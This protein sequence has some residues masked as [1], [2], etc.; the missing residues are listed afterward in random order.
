MLAEANDVCSLIGLK[1]N[2]FV[3]GL[4]EPTMK[5]GDQLI[6]KSQNM[7]KVGV[8]SRLRSPDSCY[9]RFLQTL[10]SVSAVAKSVYERAFKWIVTKC[11]SSLRAKGAGKQSLAGRQT[12][13][14]PD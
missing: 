11:N 5:V 13:A 3:D 7:E 12:N 14:F 2:R 10:F 4:T 1:T 8:F 6:R 9:R